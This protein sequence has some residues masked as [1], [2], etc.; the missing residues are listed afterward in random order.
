MNASRCAEEFPLFY[1]QLQANEKAWRQSPTRGITEALLSEA[2]DH[3]G[4]GTA[5]LI[6]SDGKLYIRVFRKDWQSRLRS[7]V[8]LFQEAML[9]S[10]QPDWA[11][12]EGAQ[13][14]INTA[15]RDGYGL[16]K[17]AGH[18]GGFGKGAGW[19]LDKRVADLPGQYLLVSHH[20]LSSAVHAETDPQ[21]ASHGPF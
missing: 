10:R 7:L 13:L 5:H 15:D 14:V 20:R 8:D 12:Y 19:V 3:G 6:F 16:P 4:G 18:P 2:L 11:S 9:T 1:P 17:E 21:I